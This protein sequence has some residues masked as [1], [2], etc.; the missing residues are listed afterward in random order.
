MAKK[1]HNIKYR[2]VCGENVSVDQSVCK[3][4]KQLT[5]QPVLQQYDASDIFN[6]D[7]T[8]LFWQL[9]PDKMHAAAGETCT[10]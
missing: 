4:W 1:R 10:G 3:D 9:L 2:S 6:T 8:G 5:L 7:E